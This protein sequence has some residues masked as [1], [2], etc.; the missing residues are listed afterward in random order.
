MKKNR[1][2]TVGTLFYNDRFVMI[3]SIL[4]S[5]ILWFTVAATSSE[6]RPT[7]IKGIPIV[8][9]LSD[10]AIGDGLQVFSK[11][12]EVAGVTVEGNRLTLGQITPDD[13]QIT[14]PR[15]LEI[16]KPG[17]YTLALVARQQGMLTEYQITSSPEPNTIDVV[18][19]RYK[20]VD[21]TVEDEISY[22]SEQGYFASTTSFSTSTVK[23]TGPEQEV[24]KVARVAAKA[25]IDGVLTETRTLKAPLVFYDEDDKVIGDETLAK[26]SVSIQEVEATIPVMPKK[27]VPI[28]A[29]Y[30]NQPAG[31]D[32]SERVTITPSTLEIAGTAEVLDAIEEIKLETL[33]FTKVSSS[34]EEYEL[35]IQL[36]SGCRNL[37]NA[38]TATVTIDMS[39]IESKALSVQEFSFRN[40]TTNRKGEVTSK[41][42]DVTVFGPTAQLEKL[43]SDDLFATIDMSKKPDFSGQG[44][45]PIKVSIKSGTSCW[46]YGEYV[47]TV[48]VTEQN[49]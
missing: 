14:T 25:D 44:E 33:D 47:A 42:V 28:V 7:T 37:S 39:G 24:S 22:K 41:K 4:V 34:K 3:F 29:Q 20:E 10:T 1:K 49:E 36:P 31:L 11:S 17:T 21:L 16:T 35:E 2:W 12:A 9:T 45:M 6:G 19:D 40:L 13:I 38:A 15:A 18:V 48:S 26:M 43:E 46:I 5:I 8:V 27:T 30:E 23:I 32:L